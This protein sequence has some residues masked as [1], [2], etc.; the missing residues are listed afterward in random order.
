VRPR[1]LVIF[2]LK[3]AAYKSTYLLTYL[4]TYCGRLPEKT[5][6]HHAGHLNKKNTH[7]EK[8]I[9][10]EHKTTK[11]GRKNCE[12]AQYDCDTAE[13]RHTAGHMGTEDEDSS[14]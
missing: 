13:H 1:R 6:V 7:T 14:I 4:L 12:S 11:K 8:E 5:N 3:C 10:Y 9:T 2:Y